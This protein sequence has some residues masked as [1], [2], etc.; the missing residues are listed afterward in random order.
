MRVLLSVGTARHATT[1]VITRCISNINGDFWNNLNTELSGRE[2]PRTEVR[3][4][5]VVTSKAALVSF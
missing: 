2:N 1:E 5:L 4:A 3:I